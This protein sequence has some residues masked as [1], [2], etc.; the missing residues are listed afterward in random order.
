MLRISLTLIIA[1]TLAAVLFAQ[2]DVLR[3][4]YV[5]FHTDSAGHESIVSSGT[6]YIHGDGR[7]RHDIVRM[8]ERISYYRLPAADVIVS[9]NHALRVGIRTELGRFPWNPSTKFVY[10][11]AI[12]KSKVAKLDRNL[13]QRAHGPMLLH[14]VADETYEMWVYHHP[15]TS[16]NPLLYPPI[17]IEST[18][19]DPDTGETDGKRIVSAARVPLEDDTFTVPYDRPVAD[20]LYR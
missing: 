11:P 16:K 1:A 15:Q 2:R 19:V 17:A 20:G 9:V 12:G 6:H 13:G 18:A 7:H 4:E 10:G 8:G 3:V 5:E 14:G